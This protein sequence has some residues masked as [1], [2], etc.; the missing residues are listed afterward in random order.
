LIILQLNAEKNFEKLRNPVDNNAWGD[1]VPTVV[2]AFFEA[3]F[4]RISMKHFLS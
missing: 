2:N 3:Q 4:N 1:F